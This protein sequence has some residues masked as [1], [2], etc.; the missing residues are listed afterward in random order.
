M[1]N[2]YD[3]HDPDS[4]STPNY[5]DHILCKSTV[6][7]VFHHSTTLVP[8]KNQYHRRHDYHDE[9]ERLVAKV[10]LNKSERILYVLK[11]CKRNPLRSRYDCECLT[12]IYF[13]DKWKDLWN[14]IENDAIKLDCYSELYYAN[15]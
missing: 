6:V 10:K 4:W 8:Y 15:G 1:G 11:D 5:Y 3:I 14:F 2:Y 9:V 7:K 12:N 13:A